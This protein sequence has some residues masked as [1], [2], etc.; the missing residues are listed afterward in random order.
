MLT[1]K[2][3]CLNNFIWEITSPNLNKVYKAI[4]WRISTPIITLPGEIIFCIGWPMT[5][6]KVQKLEC[7]LYNPNVRV[8]HWG[9]PWRLSG[10]QSLSLMFTM[11]THLCSSVIYRLVQL[12]KDWCQGAG[13]YYTGWYKDWCQ[14]AG[15]AGVTYCW[16]HECC[17][18]TESKNRKKL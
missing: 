14:G 13:G 8:S 18:T 7:E 4:F 15:D 3:L 12:Y 16:L 10:C 11:K 17:K 9:P 1:I 2:S 6:S 5:S